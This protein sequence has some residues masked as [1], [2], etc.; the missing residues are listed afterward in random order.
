MY[1]T[2]IVVDK[3]DLMEILLI[4]GIFSSNRCKC[5]L[6]TQLYLAIFLEISFHLAFWQI[7]MIQKGRRVFLGLIF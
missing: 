7:L 5:S 4:L 1:I 6:A 3:I 2:Y